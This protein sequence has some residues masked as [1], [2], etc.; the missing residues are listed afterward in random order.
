MPA[1]TINF[2][3]AE[4]AQDL[5]DVGTYDMAVKKVEMRFGKDSKQPYLNFTLAILDDGPFQNRYV[6]GMGSLSPKALWRTKKL[7]DALGVDTKEIAQLEYDEV[8]GV[9]LQPILVDKMLR[10]DVEHEEGNDGV[11]RAK[12]VEYYPIDAGRAVEAW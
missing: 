8:T 4:G 6:W 10:V 9:L 1:I 11:V 3:D 12:P 2:A 7:F 5:V